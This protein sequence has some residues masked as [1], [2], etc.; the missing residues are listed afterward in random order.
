MNLIPYGS[1]KN[2]V[3]KLVNKS[4]NNSKVD[5]HLTI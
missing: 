1:T 3:P 4:H 2:N 5:S